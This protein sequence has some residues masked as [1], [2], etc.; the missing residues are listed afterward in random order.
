MDLYL[1]KPRR[2]HTFFSREVFA[3][4]S[5]YGNELFSGRDMNDPKKP[6]YSRFGPV[7][8]YHDEWTTFELFIWRFLIINWHVK[9]R[10]PGYTCIVIGAWIHRFS[11][12]GNPSCYWP[13]IAIRLKGQR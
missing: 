3:R 6:W 11:M 4:L 8:W 10:Q 1:P 2:T 9:H 7:S 13:M 12:Y 5:G